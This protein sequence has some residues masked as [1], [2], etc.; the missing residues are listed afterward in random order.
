M[1]RVSSW[2]P[3]KFLT[4]PAELTD[5][6]V[7]SLTLR[8][9]GEEADGTALH[10]L[11]AAHVAEVLQGLVGLT[12]DF[13]K[14]GVFD[15]EGE[16]PAGSEVL[17]RPAKEG[18]FLIEV[19]RVAQEVAATEA[20]TVT[21][22]STA[23]G[24]PSIG[25]IVKWA[26]K[27]A[28][29]DVKS[30]THDKETGLT[31]IVWQDDTMNEVQTPVWVELNKRTRRR[32]KH[33]RQ[34]LAPLSDPRVR[35]LDVALAPQ[36][37]GEPAPEVLVLDRADYDAV[38]PEDDVEETETTFD[39]EARMSAIDF[40]DSKKWKVKTADETRGAVMDD[41][42]FLLRVADGLAIRKDDIFTLKV[43]ADTKTKNGN[44]RTTWTVV[45]VMTH[46]RAAGDNDS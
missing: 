11:R 5:N 21:A 2:L 31:Q 42:A 32:K 10:E 1:C 39:V 19:I 6:V 12:A 29:A 7:D 4:M 25:M 16:G 43:R 27:S 41:K 36:L 44:S 20:G 28:R 9:D 17:V 3:T 24:I 40:D 34:I 18:S 23:L 30:A 8:F 33:L 35:Q 37:A 13:D 15:I 14:A 45:K 46:R 26:T 38:R 22:V